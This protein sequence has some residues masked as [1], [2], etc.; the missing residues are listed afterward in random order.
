MDIRE[1]QTKLFA[2]AREFGYNEAELYYQRT[3]NF[4]C[5]LFKGE[6][7][8]YQSA[9]VAGVSFRGL[10]G[11]KMG[12]AFTERLTDDAIDYLLENAREN[13]QIVEG[14]EVDEVFAGSP[15][16]ENQR[17]DSERLRGVSEGE[18]IEFLKELERQ[19]LAYDERVT[20]TDYC[21]IG[22]ADAER[23]LSNSK[24]LSL[25]DRQ[26]SLYLYV[27]VVAKA[28]GE[29][30]TGSC[31]KVTRDFHSLAAAELAR[32]ACEAALS[33]L[34]AQAIQSK[35]YPV[36]LRND[37]AATLLST[38]ASIFSAEEAQ[39]GR[40]RL[41]DKVGEGVAVAG[42]NL[43]DDPFRPDG[44]ASRNFD[45][46]GSASRRLQVIGKGRLNSLLHNRKTAKKAGLE[47]TGHAHKPS[48]KGA[49]GIAPSNLFVEPTGL[50]L[51]EL[52]GGVREGVL[53]TELSGLHS[54][55]N[56]ISGDFSLA[57]LGFYIKDGKIESA[58]NQMTI[59]GNFFELLNSIEAIGGDLEFAPPGGGGYIGSPSLLVRQLSV[60]VD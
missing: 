27:S 44:L 49:I 25:S 28:G 18:K 59:A 47:S 32:D 26:N 6:I 14:E 38:Y 11:D 7:D 56:P 34:G 15:A 46:E 54:G 45:G 22:S 31:E 30:K 48:Y 53:I 36:V 39:K 13:A 24:G 10:Y 43:V 23:L 55:A 52:L 3:E 12:Y 16:Y 19:I 17:F 42:F 9:E 35:P 4:D 20:G 40:S 33:Q 29:V 8:S 21:M 50:S 37:M 58:V 2:R 51:D 41:Q 60:T 5:R 57:A 1:F